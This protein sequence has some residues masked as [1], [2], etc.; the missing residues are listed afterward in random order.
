[1][2]R[3]IG[4]DKHFELYYLTHDL[5]KMDHWIY[6]KCNNISDTKGISHLIDKDFF[7]E[8]ACIRKY[9]NKKEGKYYDTYEPNFKWP[10]ISKGNF[11]PNQTF[12]SVIVEKCQ[13][14][15][16]QLMFGNKLH[17]KSDI[18][19]EEYFS[20]KYNIFFN[21]VDHSVDSVLKP[22]DDGYLK[23]LKLYE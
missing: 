1:M 14:D 11:N 8:S 19:M 10:N 21:F 5:N 13:E 18:E 12:Y 3:V 15:T 2:F 16:L 23:C 9:Y 6:G 20:Y 22:K 4:I 7:N 17:C